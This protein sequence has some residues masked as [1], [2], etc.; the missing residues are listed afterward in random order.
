M[1]QI[2]LPLLVF[3]LGFV[4]FGGGLL[5]LV[6]RIRFS[7]C[8]LPVTADWIGE[9]SAERY[10]PMLRLLHGDDL[11]FLISQAGF[12]AQQAAEFRTQRVRVFRGYL[13][14]LRADFERVSI[15]IRVLMVQSRHDRPDLAQM[16]IRR[17][18]RFAASIAL[19]HVRLFLFRWG[20][21]S[22]DASGLMKS[23]EAL[24]LELR[25]LLPGAAAAQA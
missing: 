11:E 5:W 4:G 20:I 3:I 2:N 1:P 16:L 24:R 18:M 8:G 23:F 12:A 7:N 15:A 9:L 10:R 17:R 21:G 14:C 25:A 13:H 6:D 19:V 22:V